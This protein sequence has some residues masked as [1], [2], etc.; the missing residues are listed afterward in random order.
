MVEVLECGQDY[1]RVKA[2]NDA[3]IG[4]KRH[5]NLPGVKLSLPSMIEKDKAD[6][7]F[8]IKMGFS[9]VAA[10]FVRSSEHVQEVRDFLDAN[11]GS[12][13]KIISK[14]ENQE[15]LENLEG[16]VKLSDG[17]MIARGDLGVELP[18]CKLPTYQKEI[19]DMCFRYGKPVIIATELMKSM[20]SN[21]FPTRAEVSDVYTSVIMR[22]DAVMLSDETADRKS[23]V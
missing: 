16:I 20:V 19:L 11:G 9:Y 18:I 2:L 6:L 10:S 8:G 3:Q 4:S 5:I 7:L 15:A 23:V 21:P 22:A 17:V 13:I 14:I 1:L 12:G